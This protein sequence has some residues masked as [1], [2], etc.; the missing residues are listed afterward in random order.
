MLVAVLVAVIEA[1]A[2]AAPLWSRIVPTRLP[3]SNW[4]CATQPIKTSDTAK[5]RVRNAR[6]L[7]LFITPDDMNIRGKEV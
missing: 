2:T 1:P 3:T 5:E 6:R 4:A 7:V